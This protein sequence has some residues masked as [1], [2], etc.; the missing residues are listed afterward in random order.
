MGIDGSVWLCCV[1]TWPKFGL[2]AFLVLAA[3]RP[4]AYLGEG[5]HDYSTPVMIMAA[6]A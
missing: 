2:E 6:C 5:G 1:R 3:H 4:A